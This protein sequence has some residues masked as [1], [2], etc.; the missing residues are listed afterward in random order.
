MVRRV[1]RVFGTAKDIVVLNDEAH[2]CYTPAP[3]DEDPRRQ[4][5]AD[6]RT[7]A[8]KNAE[9]ARVWFEGLRA[10]R[11]KLGIR[12]V[13]DVS[14]T[15][16]FLQGLGLRRGH[17]FPVGRLRFRA[18]GRDRVGD[19]QGAARAGRRRLDGRRSAPLPRP[20]GPRPRRAARGRACATRRWG[21]ATRSCPR[22]SRAR[23][24]ACT[25]TTSGPSASGHGPAWAGRRCSS[26]CARTR[27]V[28]KLVYDWIAGYDRTAGRWRRRSRACP[29]SCR[30]SA[31]SMAA[32]G[33]TGRS[34]LL[35][36]SD[37]AR[38]RRCPR[39]RIQEGRRPRDRGVQ[40][41]VRRPL[42][43]PQRRRHRATRT[44]CARS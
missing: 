30:C 15:P 26:S 27:A 25:A 29:A 19:R 37:A 41:R 8:R 20:V 6:E 44:S 32:P 14:A 12:R 13:F 38:P 43:R 4:P 36:D 34:A 21:T 9:E 1:C 39:P 3:P 18:D 17:A 42:P 33:A 35:I 11:D 40:A 10:V 31:T 23:C 5:D 22:S 7:E 2:H 24:R 28:S 16:F